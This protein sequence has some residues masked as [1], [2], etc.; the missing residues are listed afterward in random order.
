MPFSA[1]RMP[2]AVRTSPLCS[3]T[4]STIGL[5]AAVPDSWTSLNAG[6]SRTLRRMNRPTAT[7]TIEI[8]NGMRQPQAMNC[9]S[10]VR[11]CMSVKTTVESS[12]PAGTPI[13]GHEP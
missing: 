10:V 7:S 8:R 6:D 1:M 2:I 12:R 3:L 13:C 11:F 4:R 5:S 9:A